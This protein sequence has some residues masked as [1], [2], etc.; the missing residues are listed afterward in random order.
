MNFSE[1]IVLITGAK[2]NLGKALSEAF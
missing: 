1:K 2:G